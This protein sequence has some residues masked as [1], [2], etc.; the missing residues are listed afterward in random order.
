MKKVVDWGGG[1]GEG[2][3][4]KEGLHYDDPCHG[5]W[6]R[7]PRGHVWGN[8]CLAIIYWTLFTDIYFWRLDPVWRMVVMKWERDLQF[9]HQ[10]KRL[11]R[12]KLVQ[13]QRIYKTW[14]PQSIIKG[15]ESP[16]D[17][18]FWMG[19]GAY[20]SP[21]TARCMFIVGDAYSLWDR[22]PIW[23]Q[24]KIA[25]PIYHTDPFLVRPIFSSLALWFLTSVQTVSRWMQ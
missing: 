13:T 4:L 3:L 21:T 11:W 17:C 22:H 1:Q 2:E 24:L 19:N 10:Q 8:F 12:R 14:Q 5:G 25:L 16:E 6:T 9:P 18:I 15:F 7:H 23:K 20:F